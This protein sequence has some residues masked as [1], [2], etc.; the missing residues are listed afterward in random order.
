MSTDEKLVKTGA[1]GPVWFAMSATF[2][3]QLKAKCFLAENGVD[4]FVPMRNQIVSDRY[5]GK[6]RRLVPAINNLIFVHT[7]KE[8]I[9]YLKSLVGYLQYMT[10]PFEGRNIPIIVPDEQMEQFIAICNTYNEKVVY[11]SAEEIC[12]ERG[13]KVKIAGGMF[14]GVEGLFIKSDKRKKS[15]VVH[16]QGVIGVMI[17]ELSDGYIQILE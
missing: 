7:T 5:K 9:H 1:E 14:D 15:V 8:R 2:G 6:V 4:S 3:R 11:I 10:K 12:L 17:V 13:V 16:V